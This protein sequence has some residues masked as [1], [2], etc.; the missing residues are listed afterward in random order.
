MRYAFHVKRKIIDMDYSY[1]RKVEI[2]EWVIVGRWFYMVAVF[3]IGILGN[4]LFSLFQVRFSFFAIAFLLLLLL[5]INSLFLRVIKN[6]KKSK[7]LE[8]LKRLSIWQIG[9]ELLFFSATIYLV[10]NQSLVSVFFILPIIS[11]SIIFGVR[12]ALITAGISAFLVNIAAL[13]E[14]FYLLIAYF[15]KSQTLL[16]SF[17]SWQ[18]KLASFDFIKTFITSIF[19]LIVAYVSG[20]SS[21]FFQKR[22]K[23]L[24]EET[25]RFRS[26]ML[27]LEQ[28]N[29]KHKLFDNNF[30]KHDEM[31]TVIN[32]QLQQKIEE[33]EKSEK[34][35]IRAFADLKTAR[36]ST[37]KEQQKT[38][39]I[40]SNFVDPIILI[41][42]NG[43]ISLFNPAAQ[44]V[45]GFVAKD[46]GSLVPPENNYSM[47]NFKNIID[48]DYGV[49]TYKELKSGN[50]LEEEVAI[51]LSGMDT[52]YKVITAEV[53][54]KADENLG[55]MKIFYNLTREKMID[56]MKSEFISIAAHQL[57]TPL[58]AIK[59][60]IKMILDGDLG[61]LNK[62][63]SSLL[64]KGYESNERIIELVNDMLNVSRIE[65]GRF[66]YNFKKEDYIK[67][68]N[69][70]I[71]SLRPLL[72]K[73]S[74]KLEF[75]VPEG[76][77]LVN[78][79]SSKMALVIQN[80]IENA[81]KYTPEFGKI[82]VYVEKEGDAVRT[83]VKDNGVGIPAADLPKLFS[84][85]FRAENVVRMQAE[86]SG[87]GLFI[88]KNIL[89]EHGSD[90]EVKSEE[91]KGS[92]FF[93][94]LPFDKLT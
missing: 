92:E 91:G 26:E 10:G 87:L 71:E 19:Y 67:L 59:W 5:L 2:N 76:V 68:I 46:L 22:E 84:K 14:C 17:S 36:E 63:Q 60:A 25:E 30:R 29:E 66:G 35:L 3:L 64:F 56:K 37:Q 80:L 62:E 18:I 16:N 69:L 33:L 50:P 27:N 21:R 6:I 34:S 45:F 61:A 40:I 23:A 15:S 31:I 43:R 38:S 93:F 1:E 48:R 44:N 20:Y 9:V 89:K 82:T 42:K 78:M 88:V 8:K 58:S 7:D 74:L 77:L 55:V 12:G 28:S 81:V 70:Q 57:R 4:L 41:N 52:T 49:K 54:D 53:K 83:G 39:A 85:F 73:K 47:E 86:G 13:Q 24:I 90:I 65:E 32:H 75:I 51:H 72:N 11:S 94:V 79:D